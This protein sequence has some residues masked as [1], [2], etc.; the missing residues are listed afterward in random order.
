MNTDLPIKT[1]LELLKLSP[2]V[3]RELAVFLITEAMEEERN[4]DKAV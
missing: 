4:H 1:L 3:K 2:D